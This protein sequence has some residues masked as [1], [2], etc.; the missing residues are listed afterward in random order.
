MGFNTS[1]LDI[2]VSKDG[3]ILLSHETWINTD[4][5]LGAEVQ[6]IEKKEITYNIYKMTYEEV[7]TLDCGSN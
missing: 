1:E 4:I 5:C 3:Q 7:K 2:V 6:A